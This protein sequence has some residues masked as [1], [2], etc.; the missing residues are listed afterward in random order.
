MSNFPALINIK[1]HHCI[2]FSKWIY[3][4]WLL[5]THAVVANLEGFITATSNAGLQAVDLCS[6]KHSEVPKHFVSRLWRSPGI[7]YLLWFSFKTGVPT[8]LLWSI[9]CIVSSRRGSGRFTCSRL[10][11]SGVHG[12]SCTS[13][14]LVKAW[15]RTLIDVILDQSGAWLG[16]P[17]VHLHEPD[18][19]N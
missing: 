16:D 2:N 3:N 12:F 9:N 17:T 5:I 8:D 6:W 13:S 18:G 14:W 15:I 19:I 11:R 4:Q 7:G 1:S 10:W